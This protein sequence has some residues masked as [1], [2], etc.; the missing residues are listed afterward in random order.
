MKKAVYNDFKELPLT[1][2]VKDIT[3]IMGVHRGIVY[4]LCSTQTFPCKKI[5]MK[6]IIPRDSFINWFNNSKNEVY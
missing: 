6:I 4:Q 1:L 2:T 5:G 3:N